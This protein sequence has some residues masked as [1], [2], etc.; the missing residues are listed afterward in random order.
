VKQRIS[1]IGIVISDYKMPGLD[2]LETLS[3]IGAINPE[4]TR[5]MLTG[6]ATMR[7]AIRATNEGL[8]GF[9]TKPFDSLELLTRLRTITR[10]NR[11]RSLLQQRDRL[12]EMNSELR[13][14]YDKTIEGWSQA[15]DLRDH[16]TEGHSRRVTELSTRLAQV[17][18]LKDEQIVH[19]RRGALLHD[20]GKLGIPDAI[21]LKPGY[22]T[23]DEW[24]IMRKHR[25]F[26]YEWLSPI[27]YL[28]PALEIPFCHHERWDGSGY[29]QGLKGEE[30]PQTARLFAI[31]DVWDAM[32]SERPYRPALQDGEVA[33]YLQAQ[34]GILF[35]PN[36]VDTFFD[37]VWQGISISGGKV[38]FSIERE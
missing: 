16:E 15:L 17:L 25:V 2:G 23:E 29:P 34:K 22:L 19:I 30:I 27:E 18:G 8:D 14:A 5:V 9:L 24:E 35:D 6:Y 21:L 3:M 36:L 12:E 4:I 10:L 1:Q 33:E 38:S 11:Y 26:A 13:N 37:H 32:H 20:I 28:R 7:S 31:I